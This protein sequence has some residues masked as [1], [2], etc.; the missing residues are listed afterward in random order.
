MMGGEAKERGN[1][2]PL[3]F[4]ICLRLSILHLR[5]KTMVERSFTFFIFWHVL[6]G[7]DRYIH[8]P[9]ATGFAHVRGLLRPV[10]DPAVMHGQVTGF[11]IEAD[12]TPVRI[13]V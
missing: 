8:N 13:V 1:P 12:L 4:A 7:N 2:V 9:A 5:C 3:S 6:T 10:P 11:Q